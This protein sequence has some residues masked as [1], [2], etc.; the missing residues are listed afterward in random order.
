MAVENLVDSFVMDGLDNVPVDLAAPGLAGGILHRWAFKVEM[1]A[2]ASD[3]STYLIA[4]LPAGA[5]L[6]DLSYISWDDL[7]S[8]G[9]PTLD[10]GIF[11]PSDRTD[12]PITDDVDAINDGLDAATATRGAKFIKTIDNVG[13]PLWD[14]VNGQ[15]TNPGGDLDIKI[16]LDDAD[17]NTGGTIQG[18]I[19]YTTN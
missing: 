6:S 7:A 9:S 11:T 17:A 1:T 5:R 14:L 2:A 12:S 16:T 8:T 3:T 13:L 18:E 4:R 15:T 10:I 19:F